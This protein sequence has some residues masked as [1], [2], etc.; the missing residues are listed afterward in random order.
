MN[1]QGITLCNPPKI[2]LNKNKKQ[3]QEVH[4][5]WF[6]LYNVLIFFKFIWSVVDLQCSDN[7]CCTTKWF[8]YTHIKKHFEV[9]KFRNEVLIS[10]LWNVGTGGGCVYLSKGSRKD[11]CGVGTIQYFD[12]SC[13]YTNLPRW[14]NWYRT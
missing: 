12:Y 5:V 11:S 1:L 4:S 10:N 9:I 2:D 13:E 3:S 8:S 6:H 7:F 14:H